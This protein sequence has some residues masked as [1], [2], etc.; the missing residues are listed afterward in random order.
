MQYAVICSALIGVLALSSQ[1]VEGTADKN[2]DKSKDKDKSKGNDKSKSNDKSEGNVEGTAQQQNTWTPPEPVSEFI[3]SCLDGKGIA[4]WTVHLDSGIFCD[5]EKVKAKTLGYGS[6]DAGQERPKCAWAGPALPADID[7]K[8][9]ARLLFADG[10]GNK[11]QDYV[12]QMDCFQDYNTDNNNGCDLYCCGK[13][14]QFATIDHKG[15]GT[16]TFTD[17][18]SA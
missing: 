14:A 18:T 15:M 17:C 6:F 10:R 3:P 2:K 9:S 11:Y 12:G 5:V 7:V 13:T 16:G 8:I 1:F 4:H